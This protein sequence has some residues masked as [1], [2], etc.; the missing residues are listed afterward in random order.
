MLVHIIAG[1]AGCRYAAQHGVAAVVVDSLRASATAAA[2]FAHGARELLVTSTVEDALAIKNTHHDM[3][4]Y[5]ERGGVPPTGFDYGNSPSEAVHS[6]DKCVIFTTTTGAG[7][8]FQA[9][10]A[11]PLLMGSTINSRFVVQYLLKNEIQE[12]V[13]IP[14]GL[15][16]KPDF[17]AQEDWVAASHI[18]QVLCGSFDEDHAP[19]WGKGHDFYCTYRKRIDTDGLTQLFSTAPHAAKLRAIGKEADILSCAQT[20]LFAALPLAVRRD[21][22]Y[23]VLK[24]ACTP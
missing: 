17:N 15:M 3:L 9:W 19:V 21:A 4:L 18:A 11:G 24:D 6:R 1:E 2:L 14:A 13:L 12:V 22:N 7:R 23:I 20:D 5:G 10:G 16:N 8:L